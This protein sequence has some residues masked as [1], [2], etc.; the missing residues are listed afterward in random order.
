MFIG[1]MDVAAILVELERMWDG[2][3]PGRE[4][5]ERSA[6]W[7]QLWRELQRPPV[8]DVAAPLLR[9]VASS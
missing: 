5:A 7:R 4:S 2:C 9:L 1:M 3:L 8:G 6:A